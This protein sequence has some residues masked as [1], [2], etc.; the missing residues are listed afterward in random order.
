VVNG[1]EQPVGML[2]NEA[3]SRVKEIAIARHTAQNGLIFWGRELL[4]SDEAERMRTNLDATKGFLE[5]LQAYNTPAKLKNLKKSREEIKAFAA[6]MRDLQTVTGLREALSEV[7]PAA[8]Y[9]STAMSVLPEGHPLAE[10]I[11]K[12]GK[13]ATAELDSLSSASGRQEL[14]R[15]LEALKSEYSAEYM[16]LH[17]AA[18]LGMREDERKRRILY[19]DERLKRL[20]TLSRIELMPVQQLR[21]FKDSLAGLKTCPHLKSSELKTNPV[22]QHCGFRP[23]IEKMKVPARVLVD[24]ADDQLDQLETEWSATLRSNLEDPSAQENLPLLP[25]KKRRIVEDFLSS[26]EL[27]EP[28]DGEFVDAVGEALKNLEKVVVRGEDVRAALLNG[29]SPVTPEE[30]MRRFRRFLE[31]QTGG[32]DGDRVRI[33]LE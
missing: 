16:K 25:D 32:K 26:G 7:G 5:T 21:G 23:A 29:G 9:L 14:L 27:P 30:M 1:K 24:R 33:V 15:R 6:G 19:D 8:D 13:R 31:K 11:H 4:T 20:N 17:T 22:C 2:L 28:L 18:R 10:K 12:E 3:G